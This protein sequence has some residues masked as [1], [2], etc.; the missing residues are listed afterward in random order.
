MV[1]ITLSTLSWTFVILLVL[2]TTL[3]ILAA[4]RKGQNPKSKVEYIYQDEFNKK[5]EQTREKNRK[6]IELIDHWFTVCRDLVPYDAPDYNE[7]VIAMAEMLADRELEGVL[8]S[9]EA[10][11]VSPGTSE[12]PLEELSNHFTKNLRRPMNERF[13]NDFNEYLKHD[14]QYYQHF[15]DSSYYELADWYTAKYAPELAS[16]KNIP[17]AYEFAEWAFDMS[18]KLLEEIFLYRHI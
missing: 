7:Q 16:E 14:P 10:L 12:D 5:L 17:E 13:Q 9:Q 4:S 3:V 2:F 18:K 15:A 11:E 8:D 1:T 6:R